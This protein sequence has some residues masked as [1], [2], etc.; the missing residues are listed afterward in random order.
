[1]CFARSLVEKKPVV[2][3]CR[4]SLWTRLSEY[5]ATWPRRMSTNGKEYPSSARATWVK[6]WASASC[7]PVTR[8][9]SAVGTPDAAP[10]KAAELASQGSLPG[11]AHYGPIDSAVDFGEVLVWTMRETDPRKVLGETGIKA[12]RGGKGG[13]AVLDLNN[14]DLQNE[15]YKGKGGWSEPSVG[16]ILQS[17]LNAE[18]ANANVVKAFTTLPMEVFALSPEKVR[19]AG[20]QIFL[21]DD[22]SGGNEAKNVCGQLIEELG[23]V[24]VDLGSGAMAMRMAEVMGDVMRYCLGRGAGRGMMSHLGV[25]GLPDADLNIIGERV[26]AHYRW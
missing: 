20:V 26:A 5:K 18:G 6:H 7:T 10:R 15:V 12:L 25:K 9:S 11:T 3:C 19:E 24:A 17:N 8:S 16:E 2:G 14:R 13:V 23:F 1:M 4:T 22:G 21:A